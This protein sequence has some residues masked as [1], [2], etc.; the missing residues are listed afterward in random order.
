MGKC[1]SCADSFLAYFFEYFFM[2]DS[3]RRL[4]ALLHAVK[5]VDSVPKSA[6]KSMIYDEFASYYIYYDKEGMIDWFIENKTNDDKYV[7]LYRGGIIK[8]MGMKVNIAFHI[9]G[10]EFAEIYFARGESSF[11]SSLYDLRYQ[12]LAVLDDGSNLQ[13][14]AVFYLPAR[15]VIQIPELGYKGLYDINGEVLE[16]K[17]VDMDLYSI[18]YDYTEVIDYRARYGN[19]IFPPHDP[20]T[21]ASL[22]FSIKQIGH[23]MTRRYIVPVKELVHG[24]ASKA[25]IVNDLRTL[26]KSS[27]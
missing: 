26:L 6:K 19:D 11:V 8:G 27:Q 21:V 20:Y 14:G 7:V 1:P 13:I 18:F 16:V 22:K 9:L 4:R 5:I 24:R 12:A 15:S 3:E 25:E 23:M 2:L 17:C 10:S